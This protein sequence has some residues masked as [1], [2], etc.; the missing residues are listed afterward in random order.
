MKKNPTKY[1]KLSLL[2]LV[3]VLGTSLIVNL[4]TTTW[5]GFVLWACAITSFVLFAKCTSYEVQA[6]SEGL[7]QALQQLGGITYAEDN[8][9][10]Q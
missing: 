7:K 9:K 6:Q 10:T 5:L 1:K 2:A 8:T 4:V 3:L